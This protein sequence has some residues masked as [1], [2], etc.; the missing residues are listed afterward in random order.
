MPAPYTTTG[1]ARVGWMNATWPLARLTATPEQLAVAVFPA[2]NYGFAP[3][4]VVA[5]ERYTVIPFV[6]WGVRIVHRRSDYPQNFVFWHLAGPGPVLQ[7][8]RDAGFV[9][10][11]IAADVPPRP[12]IP[13]RWSVIIGLVVVW[14]GLFM[15]NAGRMKS[16]FPVPGVLPCVALLLVLLLSL[17]TLWSPAVQRVV[18]KP[19]RHLGE[20]RG[21]VGL[22]AVVSGLLLVIFSIVTASGGFSMPH[23][24]ISKL[25][26]TEKGEPGR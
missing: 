23:R 8:I 3:H 13:V 22:L 6:G 26:V 14:N 16:G 7:G 18:L 5:I 24:E 1:G 15:I 11:G 2:G 17:A 19:G 20:I 25:P 9:P 12:G 10:C 21:T 4:E